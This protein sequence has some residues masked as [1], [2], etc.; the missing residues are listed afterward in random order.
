MKRTIILF[1]ALAA[2]ATNYAQ[3][4]SKK[5]TLQNSTD[6]KSDI[7]IYLPTTPCADGKAVLCCPG[8][9][10]SMLA[11]GHEGHEW[12]EYF[13]SQGIAYAVLKYRMPEGDKRIPLSDA[14][15]A[16]KTLRDSADVWSINPRAIGIMGFSAG[17]H[18]ASA[19]STHA[20]LDVRPNFSI[21]FYPVISMD[22]KLT[23]RWSCENFLGK[24]HENADSIKHWSS[25]KAVRSHLVPP[26]VVITASDD[27]L[28]APVTNAIAYYT[29]MRNAGNDCSLFVYPSGDHGFG[30]RT[31]YEHHEQMTHDLTYWLNS[32][33][34][35]SA[36]AKKI[37]CVGNSITDGHGIDMRTKYGYPA[38]LQNMLGEGYE[39]K[40]LGLS[41]RTMMNR[42]DHPYMKERAWQ[43]CLDWQP[44]VVVIKLGTNDSKEH[45]KALIKTDFAKDMQEMIDS[46]KALP[47]KPRI[48]LCTPIPAYKS[49]WTISEETITSDIIPIITKLA[50]RN[51]CEVVDLHTLFQNDGSQVMDDGIHPN[52]KGVEQMAKIIKEALLGVEGK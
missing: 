18:L 1:L 9:G 8:G 15:N 33:H 49:S 7:T 38:L 10:Y 47:S 20:P 25:D 12:A 37:A 32:L 35:P 22:K 16:M 4:I 40:N 26:A 48:I 29:A 13:T 50:K 28:V 14:Y 34:L 17:G 31:N 2:F 52:E 6:G 39:V 51:K 46:L 5:F 44:D 23:H 11:S 36:N 45:H 43:D 19:V 3:G 41:S 42:A 24:D 27:R 30:F 21:L